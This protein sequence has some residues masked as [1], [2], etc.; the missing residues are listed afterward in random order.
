MIHFVAVIAKEIVIEYSAYSEQK[1]DID[2]LAFEN[3]V[4]V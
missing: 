3:I 2:I 1:I 4:H